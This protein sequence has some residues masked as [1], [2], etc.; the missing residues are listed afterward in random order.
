M[1]FSTGA[2]TLWLTSMTRPGTN[3]G[4]WPVTVIWIVVAVLPAPVAAGRRAA[5]EQVAGGAADGEG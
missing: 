3:V 2:C 1:N 5:A 4:T